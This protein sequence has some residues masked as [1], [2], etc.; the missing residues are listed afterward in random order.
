[1]ENLPYVIS[2]ILQVFEG[3]RMTPTKD[4]QFNQT[5]KAILYEKLLWFVQKNLPISFVMLGFPMKSKNDRD[6]VL[7]KLPDMG[8]QV[9]FANFKRFGDLIR[10]IYPPGI[11]MVMVSDGY[12]F[13]DILEIGDSVV[14]E[15]KEM[16]MDMS[17]NT[18]VAW[19]DMTDFYN[20]KQAKSTIR[21]KI[22]A[23]FGIT[24]DELQRRI[25][26]DMNVNYLYKGMSIFMEE[27]EAINVYPSRNQLHKKAKL[28]TREMMLRN[29]AYSGL[30]RKEFS[31]HV[32][33]SMHPSLN[34][35]AKYSFQL[36]PSKAGKAYH[37]PWHSAL[38]LEGDDYSTIHKKDA[39]AAGYELQFR[40]GHPYNFVN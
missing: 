24:P 34:D 30:V 8:E 38:L 9:T 18:P 33:L 17:K 13:N 16:T 3:F 39:I 6:K 35:G 28:L 25:L 2:L 1:M 37:S 14:E 40:D 31:T 32:R 29:E 22:M 19:F 7:G 11:E 23:E 26:F 10:A 21:E 36:V 4:D 27:E 5:G 12:I 20:R 15:Y